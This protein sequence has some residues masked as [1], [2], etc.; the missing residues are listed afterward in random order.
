MIIQKLE[1]NLRELSY[2]FTDVR[3]LAASGCSTFALSH[4]LEWYRIEIERR[5]TEAIKAADA[6]RGEIADCKLEKEKP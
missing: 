3:E 5:L 1:D 6:L 2:R 4:T